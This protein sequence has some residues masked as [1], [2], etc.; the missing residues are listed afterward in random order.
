VAREQFVQLGLLENDMIQV[1]SGV[2]EGDSVVISDLSQ[3]TDG[4]F[5]RQ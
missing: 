3:L 5:V 2:V 4:V 1:K